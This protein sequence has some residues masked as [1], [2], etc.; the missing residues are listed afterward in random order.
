MAKNV[1]VAICRHV[2]EHS[3]ANLR[4]KIFIKEC[5]NIMQRKII[6]AKKAAAAILGLILLI[7]IFSGCGNSDQQTS[8]ETGTPSSDT[9]ETSS[10]DSE[11]AGS[12]DDSGNMEKVELTIWMPFTSTV[13]TTLE[14]S[15]VFQEWAERTNVSLSFIHPPAGQS[16]EAYTLAINSQELPDIFMTW[17]TY[18]GGNIKAVEDGV[19][20]DL[21]EYIDQGYAPNLKHLIDTVPDV[22]K[23][24]YTDDGKIITF[25]MLRI[26]EEGAWRGLITRKD[27]LDAVNMEV[28][29]TIQ[30]LEDMLVAYKDQ[31]GVET[32]FVC[33]SM[34]DYG[35]EGSALLVGAY[36]TASG[37][38]Q[39]DGKVHYGFMEDSYKDFLTLMKRWYDMGLIDKDFATRDEDSRNALYTSGKGGML[40]QNY[41]DFQNLTAAGTAIDPNFEILPLP[42]PVLNEG[43]D[44][45]LRL[46][47]PVKADECT[48]ITTACQDVKA[49]MRFLDYLF[50]DEG[51]ILANYGI[52]GTSFTWED[53]SFDD[54]DIPFLPESLKDSD[55]HPVFTDYVLDNPDN[56]AFFDF[57]GIYR[58]GNIGTGLLRN[59]MTD[60]LDDFTRQTMDL[61]SK[62]SCDYGFPYTSFT[63][64]ENNRI[65]T[66]LTDIKTY[67]SETCYQFI[68]GLKP[69]D[70]FDNFR[71]ELRKMGVDEL[72]QIYQD[73]YDRYISK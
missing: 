3:Q 8:G 54:Y 20:L 24:V 73:S 17:N 12:S 25:P 13:V 5:R 38:F 56:L 14:D 7:A 57:S 64:E 46:Y 40:I 34:T 1:D 66:L 28:P 41:G 43:D 71:E 62:G 6:K 4:M 72:I 9:A 67:A 39:I 65:S 36:N 70:E 45:H 52:E 47:Q 48:F 50:G 35:F 11:S 63:S 31:L 53:G 58:I 15:P 61:W 22:S 33:P 55:K 16:S 44:L 26:A 19:Y 49:A 69:L 18:P 27:W 29:T 21:K 2:E 42:N 68:M 10:A 32:P 23:V 51:F 60:S 59:P 30:E 37:F